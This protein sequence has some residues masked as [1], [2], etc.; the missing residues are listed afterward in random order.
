M[1]DIK[2]QEEVKKFV[3]KLAMQLNPSND[4]MEAIRLF[5]AELPSFLSLAVEQEREKCSD[6]AD[7]GD[8][9]KQR[10]LQIIKNKKI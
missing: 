5:R 9:L 10:I 1:Q 7:S 6:F 4:T 3:N 8:T 2:Q